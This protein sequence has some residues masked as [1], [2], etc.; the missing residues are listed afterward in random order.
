MLKKHIKDKIMATY[1][2]A[3]QDSLKEELETI[4]AD[5]AAAPKNKKVAEKIRD[6]VCIHMLKLKKKVYYN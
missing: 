4:A 5:K 3:M 2:D 1:N 6:E